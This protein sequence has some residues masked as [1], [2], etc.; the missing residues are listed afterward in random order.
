MSFHR[1]S[2][3]AVAERHSAPRIRIAE[4][5]ASSGRPRTARTDK[6]INHLD[7]PG[8]R[9]TVL[10]YL[11]TG[12]VYQFLLILKQFSRNYIKKFQGSGF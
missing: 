10:Q 6:N 12:C 8:T 9:T 3:A 11:Y 5:K 2:C 4:R 7:E 1:I